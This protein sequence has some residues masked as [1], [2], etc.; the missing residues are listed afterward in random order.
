MYWS[1]LDQET[2]SAD[3]RSA[4]LK[5]GDLSQ[6]AILRGNH[7]EIGCAVVLQRCC[8]PLIVG[9]K[10]IVVRRERDPRLE[11]RRQ[12]V[13]GTVPLSDG[14]DP[15]DLSHTFRAGRAEVAGLFIRSHGHVDGIASQIGSALRH[16]LGSYRCKVGSFGSLG[17]PSR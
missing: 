5:I 11:T 13:P 12:P 16:L 1:P 7:P 4:L 6:Q 17:G 8:E 10:I 9:R 2:C 3:Q 14:T 15:P